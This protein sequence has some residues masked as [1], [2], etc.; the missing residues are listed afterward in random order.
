MSIEM[1]KAVLA[2]AGSGYLA[3]TEGEQAAVRP[4]GC[5]SLWA[6][7]FGLRPESTAQ[8]SRVE[9][10]EADK[11]PH[12]RHVQRQHRQRRPGDLP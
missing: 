5:P 8:K 4:M 7:N 9:F 3:T 10:C 1:V 6:T 11:C 2:E 12:R